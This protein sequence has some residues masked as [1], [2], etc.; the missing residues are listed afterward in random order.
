M[1]SAK[2]SIKICQK[3]FVHIMVCFF[4]DSAY[5]NALWITSWWVQQGVQFKPINNI[6]FVLCFVFSIIFCGLLEGEFRKL[7]K[8]N[9][10]TMYCSYCGLYLSWCIADFNALWIARRWVQ[11]I[12]QVKSI[13]NKLVHIVVCLCHNPLRILMHYGLLGGEFS[14]LFNLNQPTISCS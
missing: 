9:Q 4:H 6:L 7:F 3:Y 8:L 1:S 14:K 13:D 11:Q 2:C 5:L 10:S 12:V